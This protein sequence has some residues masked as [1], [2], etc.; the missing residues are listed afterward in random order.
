MPI[1][2]FFI[3]Q[4][5]PR[6][7]KQNLFLQEAAEFVFCQSSTKDQDYP[8][9]GGEGEWAPSPFLSSIF[10]PLPGSVCPVS[11]SVVPGADGMKKCRVAKGCSEQRLVPLWCSLGQVQ[12]CSFG[13][14]LAQRQGQKNIFWKLLWWFLTCCYFLLPGF[15]CIK[16]KGVWWGRAVPKLH[17]SVG[18]A[19]KLCSPLAIYPVR[20][21]FYSV[22]LLGFSTLMKAVLSET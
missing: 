13:P 18:I 19:T 16:S 14:T 10:T 21:P 2:E 15:F 1:G 12:A 11:L 4:R 17:P 5:G 20:F 9:A 7:G 3:Y 22:K 6:D 8:A